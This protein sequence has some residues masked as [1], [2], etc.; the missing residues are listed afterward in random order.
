MAGGVFPSMNVG[1]NRT[2]Y[3]LHC[4]GLQYMNDLVTTMEM[5]QSMS[6]KNERLR[7]NTV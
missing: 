5:E 6:T 1:P 4:R 7:S 2:M 3:V